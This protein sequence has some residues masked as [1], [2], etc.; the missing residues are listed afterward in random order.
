[1]AT[2]LR[3]MFASAVLVFALLGT[4]GGERHRG[5]A[6]MRPE[7]PDPARSVERR[8]AAP[9]ARAKHIGLRRLFSSS[10]LLLLLSGSAG[11]QV[12]SEDAFEE[13]EQ[14][15]GWQVASK[16]YRKFFK[17]ADLDR[18]GSLSPTEFEYFGHIA[19]DSL[20]ASALRYLEVPP[21]RYGIGLSDTEA[22]SAM[23]RDLDRDGDGKLSKADIFRAVRKFAGHG[24]GE[25]VGANVKRWVEMIFDKAD[26]GGDGYLNL[27]EAEL[28]RFLVREVLV[29][30]AFGKSGADY[31]QEAGRAGFFDAWFNSLDATGDGKLDLRDLTEA[32]ESIQSIAGFFRD[33]NEQE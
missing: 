13:M 2:N 8:N 33:R 5:T 10:V 31:L 7:V 30:S 22:A 28:F 17:R 26:V 3:R 20:T 32:F 29:A 15:S 27:E 23:F 19:M 12:T 21:E 6:A 18:D 9:P 16:W 11:A 14:P 25:P 24:R 1:M 4:V